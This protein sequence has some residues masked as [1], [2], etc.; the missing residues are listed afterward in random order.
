[1]VVFNAFNVGIM[2]KFHFCPYL[3]L[4]VIDYFYHLICIIPKF[5]ISTFD[6]IDNPLLFYV[7]C[8]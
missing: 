5:G 7:I 8:N 3:I 1:M 2:Q 4:V 6:I